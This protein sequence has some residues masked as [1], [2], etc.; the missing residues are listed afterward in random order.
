VLFCSAAMAEVHTYYIPQIAAGGNSQLRIG[1][2][3]TIV[4]LG[5][6]VLNPARVTIES[7]DENGASANLL[8]QVSLSGTQ[9]VASLEREMEGR[10]VATVETYSADGSL[11]TGWAKLTTEDNIAIEAVFSIYN[12]SGTLLTTTSI[13]PRDV[14]SSATLLIN[15][16]APTSLA[17]ALAALNPPTSS[18]D[19]VIS[20]DVYDQ[21]GTWVG[22]DSISLA[23]G[24]RAANNWTELVTELV[25]S[26]DFIGSAE[27]TSSIPVFMLPL[28][29]DGV[30]LTTQDPLP[31]R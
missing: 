15:L 26:S 11:K 3:V 31:A 17:T 12:G 13:L 24:H 28:R 6:E 25:G 7:Y 27:V 19:A 2:K 21:F 29:Q 9:A 23:P 20:Y 5:T 22:S 18:G 8:K 1:T 10:G 30:Q 16:N 14:V 4:N